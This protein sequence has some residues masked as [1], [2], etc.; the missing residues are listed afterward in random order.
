MFQKFSGIEKSLW[1]RR[2]GI[3][4]FRREFLSHSAGKFRGEP[5]FNDIEFSG[6]RKFFI[7]NR[8]VSRFPLNFFVSLCR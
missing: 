1:V 3:A 8:G 4:I 7:H 2:E 6:F 5:S